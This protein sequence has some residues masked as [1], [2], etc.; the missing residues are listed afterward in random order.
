MEECLLKLTDTWVNSE[1]EHQLDE[2]PVTP[3]NEEELY[4]VAEYFKWLLTTDTEYAE[5]FWEIFNEIFYYAVHETLYSEHLGKIVER[6]MKN[7]ET[8]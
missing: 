4:D 8:E 2:P 6:D 7:G 1:L 3:I 5:K